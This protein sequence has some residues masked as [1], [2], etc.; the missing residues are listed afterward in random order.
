MNKILA[1]VLRDIADEVDAGNYQCSDEEMS[2]IISDISRLNSERPLSKEQSCQY[3]NMS[4]STFDD[5]V[6]KEL[7]LKGKKVLGFKE[8][9]WTKE[10]LDSATKMLE[11]YQL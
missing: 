7:L 3:L 2:S 8:L 1:K 10:E 5:Y 6:K 4:R 11:E 9:S